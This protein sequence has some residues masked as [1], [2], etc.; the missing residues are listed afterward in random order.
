MDRNNIWAHKGFAIQILIA[1]ILLTF[2]CLEENTVSSH[3]SRTR[4]LWGNSQGF[5][6]LQLILDLHI[7]ILAGLNMY[8]LGMNIISSFSGST[9]FLLADL[10]FFKQ[11]T[12]NLDRSFNSC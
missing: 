10:N 7:N 5:V 11:V 12:N 8:Y 1:D 4:C 6:L 9:I 2:P 3:Y